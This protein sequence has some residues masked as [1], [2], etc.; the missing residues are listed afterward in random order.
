MI[1]HKETPESNK[2]YVKALLSM[3]SL[4]G[5]CDIY[6]TVKCTDCILYQ[7]CDEEDASDNLVMVDKELQKIS[8]NFPE[9]L[10]GELL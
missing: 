10:F 8:I 1:L 6:R 9:L 4:N 5:H 7:V 3:K 2:R